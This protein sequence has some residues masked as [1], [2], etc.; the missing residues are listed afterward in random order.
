MKDSIETIWKQGFMQDHDLL[1][2]KINNLYAQKSK[3]IVDKFHRMFII[4]LWALLIGAGI[5]LTA[6]SV[7]G[8][9]FLGAFIF[10]LVM[11]LIWQGKNELTLF[12]KLDKSDSSYQYLKSFHVWIHNQM[13]HYTRI[14]RF[15]YPLLFLSICIQFRVSDPGSQLMQFLAADFPNAL[16]LFDTPLFVVLIVLFFSLI[17]AFFAKALYRAD[18]DLVYGNTIKKLEEIIDEMEELRN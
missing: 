9:P 11:T 3:N 17:L 1:T 5:I 2:P 6:L 10:F 15:F 18:L 7:F 12:T 4:N 16:L 8:F 13:D 14:Y